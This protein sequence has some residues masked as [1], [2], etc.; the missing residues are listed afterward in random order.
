VLSNEV[1]HCSRPVKLAIF[2]SISALLGNFGAAMPAGKVHPL[3]I[4]E[5]CRWA[6]DALGAPTSESAQRR[7]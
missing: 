2:R 1:H 4:V 5:H 3:K 7:R 6:V